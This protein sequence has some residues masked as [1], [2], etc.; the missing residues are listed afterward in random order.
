M[1]DIVELI[2]GYAEVSLFHLTDIILLINRGN[3]FPTYQ[4]HDIERKSSINPKHL[5]YATNADTAVEVS[6]PFILLMQRRV[7]SIHI[8]RRFGEN[9]CK[10]IAKM[11]PQKSFF[12]MLE[13]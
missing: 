11:K 6:D 5:S 10:N 3:C 9:V 4:F 2:E 7:Q 1:H 12:K 13:S 8:S